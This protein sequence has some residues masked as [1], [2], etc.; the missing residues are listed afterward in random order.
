M[1]GTLCR[2]MD[3]KEKDPQPGPR[4][5]KNTQRNATANTPPS[6]KSPPGL[7]PGCGA[8]AGAA[9]ACSN[10]RFARPLSPGKCCVPCLKHARVCG[11]MCVVASFFGGGGVN[12]ARGAGRPCCAVGPTA[13]DVRRRNLAWHPSRTDGRDKAHSAH[14]LSSL[15]GTAEDT[16]R[17]SWNPDCI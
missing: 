14:F 17:S 4:P 16:L 12:L 6:S 10:N 9:Q 1:L 11:C 2:M 7:W 3:T 13:T 5:M 15:G 8:G